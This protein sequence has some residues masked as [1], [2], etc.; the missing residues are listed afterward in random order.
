MKSTIPK[1]FVLILFILFANSHQALSW[2]IPD[3]GQT[4]CY[5]NEK[6]IPC[7]KPG[8]PFYGQDGNYIIN[9]PSYTKLDEKGEPLPDSATE[10]VMIK[11]NVTGLIWEKK[12]NDDSIHSKNNEYEWNDVSVLFI[13]NLNKNAFANFTDW[14]LPSIGD[15]SSIY[16]LNS[17]P[18]IDVNYFSDT[19]PNYYL[20]S[21]SYPINP[22]HVWAVHFFDN[23][24]SLRSKP[25]S[26]FC[27]RAVRK[28]HQLIKDFFINSDG[29]ITDKTTGLMW[30]IETSVSQKTWKEALVYCENLTLAGYSDWRLPNLKEL[31][32][33]V[34]YSKSHPA[35]FS[36]FSKNMSSFYWS[37]SSS[38]YK[39][40]S[41]FCVYFGYGSDGKRDKLE[42]FY[43]RAVRGGQSQLTD[44]LLI[45]TPK[46]A[47]KYTTGE[48]M[49]ITWESTNI[50]ED[51]KIS[52][53]TNGGKSFKTIVEQTENDGTY[54]WTVPGYSSV[55][56]MLKIE[57]VHQ[58]EKGA[59][60]SF[61]TII[62][63]LVI[64]VCKSTCR[65]SCIQE[66][67]QAASD[68]YTIFVSKGIYNET[69]DFLKKKI[70][71]KSI[72]GPKETIIDG[73]DKG[74]PVI[75]ISDSSQQSILNGFTIINGCGDEGGAVY[76]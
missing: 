56:C 4:K 61:F 15:L 6:E 8:E 21:M 69:I 41:G 44:H 36:S 31:N 73:K 11:D 45:K 54:L 27:V 2:P 26:T 66:A 72:H 5:D 30:Q 51:L 40:S 67:I 25:L 42:T 24:K 43:V 18:L 13:N 52:I 37:S 55:N 50:Y 62:N 75:S 68:N 12:T 65:Y 64:N 23:L 20:S 14:H 53:S 3:T 9:P 46:Q 57:P 35:I 32:S 48:I 60:Q 63:P 29:T 7:P 71:I 59:T 19:S 70:V 76:F 1:Y 38:V 58:N 49:P 28:Q 74:R 17:N 39:P 10:W 33:I 16:L 34:D 47:E 22:K